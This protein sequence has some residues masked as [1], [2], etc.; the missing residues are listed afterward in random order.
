MPAIRVQHVGRT[1]T[2]SGM[3][4]SP[5]RIVR[6]WSARATPAGAQAYL[7]HFERSVLPALRRLAGHRGVLVLR[8]PGDEE[9]GITVLTLWTSM[10]AVRDF[11]GP[12]AS[13][14][15]V[16]PEARAALTAFD[17]HAEHFELVLHAEP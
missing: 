5:P 4:T 12:D 13:I 7:E 10:E 3:P 15:V 11:T 6:A 17:R 9:I 2:L 16:E 8:L 1:G 14:A